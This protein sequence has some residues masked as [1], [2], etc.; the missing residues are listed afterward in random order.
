MP[1]DE[2]AY[3]HPTKI[4]EAFRMCKLT[5]RAPDRPTSGSIP[6]K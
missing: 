3:L 2:F 1:K 5:Y 6:F 4:I